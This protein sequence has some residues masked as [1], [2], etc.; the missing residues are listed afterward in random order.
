M[1]VFHLQFGFDAC[2]PEELTELV[3]ALRER[4]TPYVHTA[5]D[6]RNPHHESR[7]LHDAQLDVL[8]PAADAVITL[9]RGA[10]GE[11]RRRWGREAL[12][13]PHPHVVELPTAARLRARRRRAPGDPFR[14]G[15]HVKSLRA[16][17][18]PL[19]ILPALVDVTGR[20]PGAVLQV[21]AHRD[22]L[23]DDGARR[24]PRLAA[25]L[26]HHA[27]AGRLELQVHDFLPDDELWRYL[28]S[29]DVS[30]LPYR[31]GT[32]S[33]WLEACRD[34]G[35]TVVA[36]TCG[37]FADQGPVL[38]Y[39]HDER[40]FERGHARR[41]DRAGLRRAAAVG[42]V[43]RGAPLPAAAGG[44]GSRGPLPLPGVMTRPLR[45]C[46][47]AS[48]RFPVREPFVGGLEAHTHALAR[49]LTRRGH[50]VSLF[51][52]PGSDP[53]LPVTELAVPGFVPSLGAR[54]DVGAMPDLWMAEHHAY[55]GL[56]LQ[57][58]EDG[59]RRFD[60]VHNNSLHHLP[61]AM[62]GALRIPTVTTLHTPPLAW[63]ES[64]ALLADGAGSF[65]AVSAHTARAWAHVVPSRVVLNGVDTRRWVPGR[66]GGPAVWS[67]RLVPEKAPHLALD[68][69]RRAGTPIALAGPALDPEY[70]RREI[71]PRLGPDAVHVGH[72]DHRSL[73]D[74]LGRAS[75]AVV[76]PEWDEPY[77]LVAS[78][79]LACGTPVAAVARGALPEI[80]D[81]TVGAL[82]RPG[83][84]DGLARA[85][86]TARTRSR[87]AARERAERLFSLT[88]MVDDYERTY[89]ELVDGRLAA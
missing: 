87:A 38:S 47:I 43:P 73:A 44:G 68:A 25:Y 60:V 48:S 86:R 45:I 53:R 8:I 78:E 33:G 71:A 18:D 17:M 51:A 28:A 16:S 62:A 79:A 76:T 23:D 85:I 74:L 67:G 56:M 27:E 66:G 4:G 1:D 9:T 64:A 58:V 89:H 69:A 7:E 10:A 59:V 54:V 36:P 5:H 46:L 37:Y 75:V 70:F 12:V 63:L 55:L 32:H 13:L 11:I 49:E 72:L 22:V 20:L 39:V 80:V 82:A 30:V 84:E 15:L 40:S 2:S 52:A 24:D 83:D 77:G 35:T 26:R 61:V 42:G 41:G 29:L 57:L 19:R 6:L 65:T 31:F 34:L 88:R 21:N 3:A 50:A 14:I 81:D